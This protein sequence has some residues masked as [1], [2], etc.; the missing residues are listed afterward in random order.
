MEDRTP[1]TKD[2]DR[3]VYQGAGHAERDDRR[4]EDLS[5]RQDPPV[6]DVGSPFSQLAADLDDR[7]PSDNEREKAKKRQVAPAVGPAHSSV[8][9][10]DDNSRSRPKRRCSLSSPGGATET[11]AGVAGVRDETMAPTIA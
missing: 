9:H 7:D 8:L 5:G 3:E 6:L 11:A 1:P 2:G 10:R 4:P